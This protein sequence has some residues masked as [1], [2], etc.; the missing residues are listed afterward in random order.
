MTSYIVLWDIIEHMFRFGNIEKGLLKYVKI[1]EKA[2]LKE[3]IEKGIQRNILR[4]E[5][6]KIHLLNALEFI[7]I[8]DEMGIDTSKLCDY[9]SWYEFED[10][11]AKKFYDFG[12]ECILEYNHNKIVRF[13]IDIIAIDSVLKRALIIECKH[14]RKSI[15]M[16]SLEKIVSDH[17]LRIEK[18]INH[19]EWIATDIP[20]LRKIEIFIPIIITLKK[21]AI[22]IINGVPIVSL[23][24]LNDFLANFDKY[25]EALNVKTFKNKCFV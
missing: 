20:K 14:W 23:Y 5:D 3:I 6:D 4:E 11:I 7:L 12:W 13:Q 2:K 1:N 15:G 17:M 18:F 9:I 8:I 16:G 19:C 10:F 25:L 24:H 21:G 22:K